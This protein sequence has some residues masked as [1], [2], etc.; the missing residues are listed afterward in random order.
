[1][2]RFGPGDVYWI[3]SNQPHLFKCDPPY[4]TK[5]NP[6]HAHSMSVYFRQSG[7]LAQ[8]FSLPELKG[9]SGF[10]RKNNG[11]YK[12]RST[13]GEPLGGLFRSIGNTRDSQRIILFLQLLQ[14]FAFQAQKETL[15]GEEA[16]SLKELEYIR[17]NDVYQFTMKHFHEKISLEK[18]AEIAH[19]TPQAFCRYFKRS[20]RK[21]YM[22]FLN[23]VRVNH[24][25]KLIC[26][27]ENT[28]LSQVAAACGF[29]NAS[30]FTRTFKRIAGVAP[31]VFRKKFLGSTS[32]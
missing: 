3:S 18:A 27:K 20:T 12:T 31:F 15:S 4:F 25:R 11:I 29:E 16:R 9:T 21:T 28:P 2:G 13:Q 23:E 7:P 6:G 26:D 10:I 14:Q 5:E 17:M 24:A 1:M 30:G 8:L 19:M 32:I 22:H